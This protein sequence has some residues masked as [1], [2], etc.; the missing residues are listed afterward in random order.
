M[1][2]ARV[3]RKAVQPS[4]PRLRRCRMSMAV[5]YI[6]QH[7]NLQP[8]AYLLV[9][10]AGVAIAG[11]VL[12]R[13]SAGGG[14]EAVAQ[15]TPATPKPQQPTDVELVISGDGGSQPRYAVPEFVAASPDVAEVAKV[16]GPVLWDDLQFERDVALIPRDA[17]ATVPAA[18]TAEQIPFAGWREIGAEA[19]VFGS[20]QRVGANV[21]VQVRLFNVRT[22]QQVFAQEY[23]GPATNP[24]QFAHS[25]SDDIHKQQR[26]LRGV[27]RSKLA[28]VS[29]RTRERVAGTVQNR[30]AKEIWIS[31]YDGAN[32]R[33]VTITRDANGFPAWSPDARAIAYTSWRRIATGGQPDILVSHIYQ[34]LL[35]TPT[36]GIGSNYLPSYS[37]DG[38]RIAFIS[39]RD[40]NMEVYT[41]NRDGSGV[42]RLTNHPAAEASPTWSP[43]G[44]QIAFVSDRTGQPQIYVMNADGSGVQRLPLPDS[45]ADKPTWSPAPYNE[46]AYSAQVA[47]GFDIHIYTFATGATR[48]ITSGEGTN[49]SPSYSA[50]GKHIAFSSSR[51]GRYQIFTIGRDGNGIKQITRDGTNTTPSWSN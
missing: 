36:K 51:A 38:T 4:D 31:D 25:I 48:S 46:I 1:N 13:A 34:G 23:S 2:I 33:R 32:Q 44:A 19:V 10:T 11:G 30:D 12:M 28:F 16:I 42:R 27:A 17:A 47:G 49:E 50:N 26:Q 40:G 18:R 41:V 29:D 24:R 8:S 9:V 39:N 43:S 15:Q 7:R 5:T 45:Y 3:F 35:E 20:V 21:S 14:L 37:P 22:R 6:T